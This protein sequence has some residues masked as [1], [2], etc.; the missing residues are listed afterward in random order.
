MALV[1]KTA[2][3]TKYQ[4]W[5]QQNKQRLSEKRKRLYAEDPDYR[6]RALNA[7][8]TRRASELPQPIPDGLTASTAIPS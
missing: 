6:E 2:K 1:F 3:P 8:K 4:E 7:A 5:Y